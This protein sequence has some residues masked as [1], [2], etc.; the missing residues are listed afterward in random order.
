[1]EK[2]ENAWENGDRWI[3][4]T[5]GSI[6]ARRSTVIILMV[7]QIR[8]IMVLQGVELEGKGNTPRFLVFGSPAASMRKH[9]LAEKL[10]QK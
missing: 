10:H 2:T 7:L 6:Q 8:E 3:D 1:M 4:R 9:G 5:T